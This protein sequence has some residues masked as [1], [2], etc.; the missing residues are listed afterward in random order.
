MRREAFEQ[1]VRRLAARLPAE[2][3]DGVVG[4][5]VSP[6]AKPHPTRE[7]IF[8][9]GECIPL[10]TGDE[11]GRAIQSRIVL[12]HGSFQA[13]DQL[14]EDF[15]WEGEAWETLTHEL[16]HHLEWRAGAPELEAYDE[17]AEQNF[18]RHEGEPFDPLFFLDGHEA[19]PGVYEV[20]DDVFVDRQVRALPATLDLEWHG[21]SWRIPVPPALRLPA[22]LHVEGVRPEPPG[23]LIVVL[24]RK[25]RLLDLFRATPLSEATARAERLG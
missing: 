2:S 3:L 20:D 4:I 22:F 14:D 10:A 17:A 9:L 7:G 15:D 6:R 5:D 12:Y 1:L 24:R 13:L 19:A 8:T 23:D 21:R 11:G 18:A 25:P 16:R